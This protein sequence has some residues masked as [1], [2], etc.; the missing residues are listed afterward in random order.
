MKT[1]I[2]LLAFLFQPIQFAKAECLLISDGMTKGLKYFEKSTSTP[3]DENLKKLLLDAKAILDSKNWRLVSENQYHTEIQILN[4]ERAFK[5]SKYLACE[6][7]AAAQ[8]KS[9]DEIASGPGIDCFLEAS[10]RLEKSSVN[11]FYSA[12]LILKLNTKTTKVGNEYH[13]QTTLKPI[14]PVAG[15]WTQ[16]NQSVSAKI[17]NLKYRGN[18]NLELSS[19]NPKSAKLYFDFQDKKLQKMDLLTMKEN[20]QLFALA[21]VLED[22]KNII[23]HSKTAQLLPVCK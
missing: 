15:S 17:S 1:H 21:S 2:L 3:E 7:K 8:N 4:E 23:V 9:N 19:V 5:D 16:L 20:F 22:F 14:R 13:Y 6:K 12:N 10:E 11:R 18:L